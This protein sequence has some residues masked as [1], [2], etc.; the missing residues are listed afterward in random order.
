MEMLGKDIT[1]KQYSNYKD[2]GT[3]WL[4]QIPGHWDIIKMKYLF[5]DHSE[6]GKPDAELLSVT[7]D[8][9]VVPRNWVENRMV[10]PSGGL[11]TFKFIQKGDFAISLRS[12]EGGLELC[13]HDGI[14]SP[15]YT[16]LKSKQ[17]IINCYFKYL[18]KSSSFISEI[19]TSVV[20]IRE[21]KNISF[22]ELSYS[23]IPIP[24]ISEQSAIADF[25]KKK[26]EQ[27]DRAIAI[28][29]KQV[30]LLKERQQVLIQQAVTKGLNSNTPMKDSGVEWIGKIPLKWALHKLNNILVER[31]EPGDD[32][33][34]LLSVSI[35]N[36]VSSEEL[37]DEDNIRGRIK[38]ED[39]SSYKRVN[40]GD[41]TYNMM[42]AWQG[43]IGSVETTGMVSPAYVVAAPIQVINSKFLE[44][45]YRT[46]LF[47]QQ[48]DRFSKGITDFR[49]RLYWN[50]FKQLITILPP[51][52]EQNSIVEFVS[53]IT[54]KTEKLVTLKNKEVE[55]LKE[56]KTSLIDA[57]VTGKIRVS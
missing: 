20:G 52:E 22:P 17:N 2:L 53:N 5:R 8:Q 30:T 34:P 7:Q 46:P 45:Q 42:R 32:S 1:V 35:H 25:L 54:S 48:M 57:V 10:M 43:A 49:K 55:T 40:K 21:G 51:I 26:A 9:G 28:K 16:V 39:K 19:Q 27:I 3:E 15:A 29:E 36:A 47:I 56:Y 33:L 23:L 50:E 11:K 18:F 13:H 38:I 44:Y 4:Q 14:I 6:K 41:I 31:K 24:S 37:A 12:F